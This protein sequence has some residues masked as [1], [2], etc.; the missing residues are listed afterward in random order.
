M[1]LASEGASQQ[2]VM[3]SGCIEQ[4]ASESED[5]LGLLQ[6]HASLLVTIGIVALLPVKSVSLVNPAQLLC[7]SQ[8][9]DAR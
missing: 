7:H 2:M 8:S 5:G 3:L 1:D 9:S 6:Q 4:M